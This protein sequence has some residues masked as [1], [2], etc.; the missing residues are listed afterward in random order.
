MSDAGYWAL[1]G[2]FLRPLA[3][4]D[5]P[6]LMRLSNGT[7]EDAERSYDRIE[8]PMSPA[9]AASW[10]A[11]YLNEA[12]S[13]DRRAFAI[14]RAADAVTRAES[15]ANPRA[16][17]NAIPRAEP[18]AA[19]A[20]PND[21]PLGLVDVTKPLG[22]VDVAEPL[23][24][25]DVWE[26]DRRSGVFRAGIKMLPGE[27]GKG[28]ATRAFARVLDYYF[29]ELRYQKCGVYIYDFNQNSIHFH[30][31]FGFVEEGRLR[32]EYFTQGRFHDAIWYGL[33]VEDYG[34]WRAS[35]PAR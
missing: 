16:E 1:G 20:D 11:A 22:L 14:M 32:R 12:A 30:E 35:H 17:P 31:K 5:E 23:G 25:V 3:L 26:A 33:L 19:T 28:Q 8:L 29:Y 24:L 21:K 2:I 34:A 27:S 4:G 9:D 13:G 10:L 6:V 7:A 15:N 18:R